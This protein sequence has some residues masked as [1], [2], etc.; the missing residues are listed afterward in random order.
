MDVSRG[1]GANPVRQLLC[2]EL[3]GR[4]CLGIP[5]VEI[6]T[7]GVWY[8]CGGHPTYSKLVEARCECWDPKVFWKDSLLSN[9]CPGFIKVVVFD[10]S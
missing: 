2:G 6:E 9:V 4:P 7:V 10:R 1:I 5:V 3:V 8:H